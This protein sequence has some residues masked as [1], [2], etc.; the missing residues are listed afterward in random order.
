MADL[1]DFG[2][3]DDVDDVLAVYVNN[4]LAS[5]LRS[6]YKN[7]E[8]LAADKTLTDADTPIQRLDCNGAARIVKVP[9][10]DAVEN[11]PF[12]IV[13][14]SSGAY[15]ITVKNNAGTEIIATINQGRAVM[16]YPSGVGGYL[17]AAAEGSIPLRA[18]MWATAAAASPLTIS[19]ARPSCASCCTQPAV[20]ARSGSARRKPASSPDSSPR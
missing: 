2:Y 4:L 17:T 16:V 20:S 8:T 5:T 10:E 13:N 15:A 9:T 6:E 7:V 1:N 18:A 3:T 19:D 12:F 14:S 11:H